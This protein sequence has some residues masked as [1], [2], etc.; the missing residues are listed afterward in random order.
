MKPKDIMTNLV[1]SLGNMSSGEDSD[2]DDDVLQTSAFMVKTRASINTLPNIDTD[3]DPRLESSQ[4]PPSDV[5]DVK[6]H[7][8]Y[9]D[10]PNFKGVI[11]AISD[12][13]ADSCILGMNAKV[14][15]YT[16][17]YANLVGYDPNTTRTKKSQLLLH[18][19]K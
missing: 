4:D 18:S 13:G 11:Y 16:G 10:N 2:T 15:S 7:F 12:G 6:A 14:L 17:S 3:L 8:E 1:D 19:L 9:R 5:I